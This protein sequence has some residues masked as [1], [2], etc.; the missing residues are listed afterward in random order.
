MR[1]KLHSNSV[2]ENLVRKVDLYDNN[3]VNNTY[4]S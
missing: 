2:I 3:K 1:Q 4:Y